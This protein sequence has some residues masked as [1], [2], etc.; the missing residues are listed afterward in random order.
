MKAALGVVAIA[1]A[2]RLAL[3]ALVPLVPDEAYYWEW[4]RHLASGYFDHPPAIAWIVR[5]GTAIGGDTPFGVR[6][7]VI[8][9]GTAGCIMV[10]ALAHRLAGARAALRAAVFMSAVPLAGIGLV[11]AT[12]DVPLL[13]FAAAALYTVDLAISGAA[14]AVS[15][16]ATSTRSD[17]MALAWWAATG[18]A[19]GAALLS[20]YTAVLIPAGVAVGCALS[21]ALRREFLRPGPYV[22]CAIAAAMFAPVVAWN[23]SHAW[24]SFAFQIRHGLGPPR[25]SPLSRELELLGVQLALVTPILLPLI[26]TSVVAAIRQ[27]DVARPFVLAS[28]AAFVWTFFAFSAIRHPVSPNWPALAFLP[29][30]ILLATHEPGRQAARWERAGVALGAIVIL[31]LSIHALHPWLPLQPRRDPMAQAYGWDELAHGVEADD[32]RT[33][34]PGVRVW[35]A[36]DRYQEAS[37]LAW[38][39]P[40]HPSVFSLELA[41]RRNEFDYWPTASDSVRLGDALTVVLDET[42]DDPVPVR[43][44]APFF[45]EVSR[46]ALVEMH[47][48][49]G[50]VVAR[51]RIWHF[52]RLTV[53]LSATL[54][55]PPT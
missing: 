29:G 27:P 1:A 5:A 31:G 6:F 9:L 45:A 51:R 36:A 53:P 48:G 37:E 2:I 46:G 4:S 44:L 19:I 42:A 49:A 3:S 13:A 55:R 25:G 14:S 21:P 23:A 18:L 26:A 50:R 15:H 41:S 35:I 33:V 11:L 12:P 16:T 47:W 43:R 39:L 32:H 24:V 28:V 17:Q 8:V 20:K 38:N 52:L 34:P 54:G 40:Q 22:A 30:I 7:M 10:V